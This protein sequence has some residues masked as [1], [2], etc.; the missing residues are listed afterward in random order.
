MCVE[1]MDKAFTF[2]NPCVAAAA[3]LVGI[4]GF[5]FGSPQHKALESD[6]ES[7]SHHAH[8]AF[9]EAGC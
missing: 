5:K 4:L 2:R 8:A 6:S 1:E 3:P 9:M 7:A